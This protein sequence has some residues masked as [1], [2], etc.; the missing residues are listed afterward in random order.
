[1]QSQSREIT[2]GRMTR[3]EG[4]FI[5]CC[6]IRNDPLKYTKLTYIF[7]YI[8]KISVTTKKSCTRELY[9]DFLIAEEVLYSKNISIA[10]S[11]LLILMAMRFMPVR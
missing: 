2:A 5:V 3:F 10:E 8:I 9:N 1:M 7:T 6:I 4:S 11:T